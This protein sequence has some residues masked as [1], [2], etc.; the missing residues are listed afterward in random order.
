[1]ESIINEYDDCNKFLNL[2][3][4]LVLDNS[5]KVVQKCSQSL[6]LFSQIDSNQKKMSLLFQEYSISTRILHFLNLVE[7]HHCKLINKNAN[8]VCTQIIK[9]FHAWFESFYEMKKQCPKDFNIVDVND[10]S[11]DS[12][13]CY[14]WIEDL[15]IK[16]YLQ[17][18][19]NLITLFFRHAICPK[20]LYRMSVI[21]EFDHFD[22]YFVHNILSCDN[23]QLIVLCSFHNLIFINVTNFHCFV[24]KKQSGDFRKLANHKWSLLLYY[25]DLS[26]DFD[27]MPNINVLPPMFFKSKDACYL[28]QK[29]DDRTVCIHILK[30]GNNGPTISKFFQFTDR[31]PLKVIKFVVCGEYLVLLTKGHIQVVPMKTPCA[32]YLI[33]NRSSDEELDLSD[34]I[35]NDTFAYHQIVLANEG[36]SYTHDKL[37]L[38]SCSNRKKIAKI[39]TRYLSFHWHKIVKND[40]KFHLIACSFG[41][42]IQLLPFHQII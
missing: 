9:K 27:L 42:K 38:I 16:V 26:F 35:D 19:K 39:T 12:H 30:M 41:C 8:E 11:L 15:G 10:S 17:L 22:H 33:N 2:I 31:F 14:C 20:V 7:L 32:Y 34:V 6:I 37:F 23:Q 21:H 36:C 13:G 4:A 18:K 25:H 29:V 3:K 24:T 40:S 1:M 5:E 28:L